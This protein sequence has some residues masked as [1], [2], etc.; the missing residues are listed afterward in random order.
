MA[1]GRLLSLKRA[2]KLTKPS[3]GTRPSSLA[4]RVKPSHSVWLNPIAKPYWPYTRTIG[5]I[6]DIF[7]MFDL[8][9]DG[10]DKAVAHLMAG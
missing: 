2:T 7:E 8:S 4:N 1:P 10:L 9:L 6:A 3:F 5:M